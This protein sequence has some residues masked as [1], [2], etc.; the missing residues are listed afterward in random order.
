MKTGYSRNNVAYL[1]E[2]KTKSQSWKYQQ[3]KAALS[4]GP[5]F[6]S[7]PAIADGKFFG[8]V[9]LT[10]ST[11]AAGFLCPLLHLC[12][13][14][15][16]F[17]PSFPQPPT[18]AVSH[19]TWNLR[20]A[21]G[22]RDAEQKAVTSSGAGPGQSG[23]GMGAKK[24]LWCWVL[25][26]GCPDRAGGEREPACRGRACRGPAS[27]L[28]YREWVRLVKGR[29][30]GGFRK[31]EVHGPPRG[32]CTGRVRALSLLP[33]QPQQWHLVTRPFD[34]EFNLKTLYFPLHWFLYFATLKIQW[35]FGLLKDLKKP[36]I[37]RN[38]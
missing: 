12:L 2:W 4:S 10:H 25:P 35:Q 37:W 17:T 24:Q 28:F 11:V 32:G 6:E 5:P 19:G 30:R 26:W 21:P 34:S 7:F 3:N 13:R 1:W 33:F 15:H 36:T 22:P 23:G 20:N 8:E 18:Q 31:R 29:G 14:S 38:I 27:A 9:S 16:V